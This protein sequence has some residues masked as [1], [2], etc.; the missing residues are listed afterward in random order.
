MEIVHT[1]GKM[2]ATSPGIVAAGKQLKRRL[3]PMWY[4]SRAPK[5][6]TE[7]AER[8]A[9]ASE[10][11]IAHAK[12]HSTP[13]KA[14]LDPVLDAKGMRR[15][16]GKQAAYLAGGTALA[17]GANEL[18]RNSVA[19]NYG[20]VKVTATHL[21][22][23]S[24]ARVPVP[25]RPN[26]LL[27]PI[28]R[29]QWAADQGARRM[30]Q[31]FTQGAADAVKDNMPKIPNMNL[32]PLAQGGK[33]MGA[34]IAGAGLIAGAAKVVGDA[35]N[36]NAARNAAKQATK[37]AQLYTGGGVA[38]AGLIGGGIALNGRKKK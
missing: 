12:G 15:L 13:S 26:A 23:I 34:G 21:V 27:H 17:L 30:G 25:G 8:N 2:G 14:A 20:Y 31:N 1:P 35:M 22:P 6:A 32:E 7:L 3:A 29:G 24:K 36:N 16:H 18:R 11:K 37:R 10:K 38:G 9:S 33:A 5:N 28:K 19:K 4:K